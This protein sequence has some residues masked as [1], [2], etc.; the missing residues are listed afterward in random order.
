MDGGVIV[1]PHAGAWIETQK[2]VNPS[3]L[4]KSLPTRERGLKPI[5]PIILFLPS[6]V[7][8]HA[9]AWIETHGSLS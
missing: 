9:G 1:A 8:P 7:A 4:L 5:N 6:P 2:T 3:C